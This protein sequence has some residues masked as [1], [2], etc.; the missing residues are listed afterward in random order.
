MLAVVYFLFFYF[1]KLAVAL[2]QCSWQS[3]YPMDFYANESLGDWTVNNAAYR[4]AVIK[5][6]RSTL[7]VEYDQDLKSIPS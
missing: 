5:K 4:S 2:R 6:R 1:F 3:V 7:K